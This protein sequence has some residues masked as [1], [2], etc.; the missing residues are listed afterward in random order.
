MPEIP[1]ISEALSMIHRARSAASDYDLITA[2]ELTWG[3]TEKTLRQYAAHVYPAG[4]DLWPIPFT[5]EHAANNIS[6]PRIVT[7]Y[8]AAHCLHDA[9]TQNEFNLDAVQTLINDASM[10]ITTIEGFTTRFERNPRR[11]ADNALSR[12]EEQ[13]T[14][15]ATT[16]CFLTAEEAIRTILQY[17]A[18]LQAIPIET[19]ADERSFTERLSTEHSKPDLLERYIDAEST[20]FMVSLRPPSERMARNFIE[21]A[22][23][24]IDAAAA[25][26]VE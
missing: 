8:A 19:D 12:A 16:E 24:F 3:A 4:D 17:L 7:W 1:E 25:L 20:R 23:N 13:L 22:R 2:S 14:C 21:N 18:H 6:E 15:G 11:T 5:A 26:V 10:L 9:T